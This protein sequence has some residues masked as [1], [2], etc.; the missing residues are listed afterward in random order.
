[1]VEKEN[2]DFIAVAGQDDVR[3][4]AFSQ[5]NTTEFIKVVVIIAVQSFPVLYYVYKTQRT[6]AY[7][8]R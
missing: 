6:G 3:V 7:H 5:R 2:N 8:H 1:M 4:F